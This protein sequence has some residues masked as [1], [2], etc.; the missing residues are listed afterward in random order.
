MIRRHINWA[1]RDVQG[2]ILV[3]VTSQINNFSQGFIRK[4]QQINIT[5]QEP[6]LN[7][8]L[9]MKHIRVWNKEGFPANLQVLSNSCY[10]YFSFLPLFLPAGT[11]NKKSLLL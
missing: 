4:K 5:L 10:I 6:N 9:T 8:H 2:I 3:Y 7:M 1:V 11:K